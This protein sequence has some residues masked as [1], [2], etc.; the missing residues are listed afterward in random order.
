MKAPSE[1][2]D[3]QLA[4]QSDSGQAMP[5]T[6]M[7][8]GMSLPRQ[9]MVLAL[10]P[11]LQNLM[12]VAV[13]FVDMMLAGRM[14]RGQ[15]ASTIMDMMGA[16][17]YLM[18]LLMIIQGA[19]GTG[20]VAVISRST[21]ARDMKIARLALGQSLSL[22]VVSG[23][24]SGALIWFTVPYLASF[25]SLNEQASEYLISY[26]RILAFSAPMS[27]VVFV[28]GSCLRGYGETMKPFLVMC[29]VNAVNVVL[30]LAF[31]YRLDWGV[32]GLAWGSF[33]SWVLGAAL[34]LWFLSPRDKVDKQ[35]ASGE[36]FVL[37]KKYLLFHRETV[38]RILNISFPAMIEILIMWSVNVVAVSFIGQLQQ[39]A[40]G[41]HAMVVRLESLS[42]MP[43]FAVGLAASTLVGQYLGAG[44]KEMA[45]KSVRYCWFLALVTMG[46]SGVLIAIFNKEVL[47][48]FGNV[49]PYQLDAAASTLRFTGCFQ[50]VA[51]T[52][53]VMK[54]SLRGAGA[55]RMVTRYA[56]ISQI[57]IRV[58]AL[59]LAMHYFEMS[60]LNVWQVMMLDVLVQA[61]VFVTKYY[62][63][64]WLETKV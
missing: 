25:F 1:K 64:H 55:T 24:F 54:M 43:G 26:M 60:L 2:V 8:G 46:G 15:E 13:G 35:G 63:G 52:M 47:T 53:M 21:G 61:I 51:A 57:G 36:S 14:E 44:D 56:F 19:M 22:A 5:L 42:F 18:W 58:I 62:Q 50:V 32:A 40:V 20:A 38:A 17:L 9:I 31:V 39:G 10:W 12:G 29:L 3:S 7:L 28:A 41:A 4:I 6:G 48:M 23:V 16:S 34:I 59:W 11:F 37:R 45:K 30:S 49:E 33:W 27:G